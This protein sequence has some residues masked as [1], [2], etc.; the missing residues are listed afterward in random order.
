NHRDDCAGENMTWRRP[1]RMCERPHARPCLYHHLRHGCGSSNIVLNLLRF[2]RVTNG[3]RDLRAD[4]YLQVASRMMRE[5]L[6]RNGFDFR[7]IELLPLYAPAPAEKPAPIASRR[8]M[9]FH[10]GSLVPNKGVWLLARGLDSLPENVELVF[11]GAGPL[12]AELA[13]YVKRR[14]LS[15]RI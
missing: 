13:A 3:L 5:N 2:H 6:M 14:D 1:R 15:E 4:S 10:P 7:R 8:R 9:V 12:E 11:A